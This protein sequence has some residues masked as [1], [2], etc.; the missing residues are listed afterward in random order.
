MSSFSPVFWSLMGLYCLVIIGVAVYFSKFIRNADD[1]FGAS[2]VTP[3]WAAGLSYFMTAFS[4]SAFI[5]AASFTYRFGGLSVM[6]LLLT[7]FT[8]LAG[9]YIFSA[10]W[11]RTGCKT[12]IEFLQ[13][14]FGNRSAKFFVATG[15]PIRILDNANRIYVTGVLTHVILDIPL[16]VGASATALIAF[17]SAV[18]GGFLSVVI[19][20]AI[21]AVVLAIITM[22][23]ATF[24]LIKVGGMGELMASLPQGYWSMS[25]EGSEYNFAFVAALALVGIFS[26]NGYW[27]LV[28]R[29]VSVKTE[30]DARRVSLTSAISYYLLFPLFTLPPIIAVVLVPGLSGAVETEQSYLRLAAMV[31]PAG[32]LGIFFFA[33]VSAAVTSLNAEFNVVAQIVVEDILRPVR[34][35]FVERHGVRLGRVLMALMAFACLVVSLLIPLLGGSY[36]FL[37]TLMGMTTLPTFMPLLFGLL[38]RKTPGWGAML[39]FLLGILI[40]LILGFGFG[41]PLAW[42]IAGNF[43]VTLVTLLVSGYVDSSEHV[44][45]V[46]TL[47][48]RLS[49]RPV[50]EEPEAEAVAEPVAGESAAG[51][52]AAAGKS[53]MVPVLGWSLLILAGISLLALLAPSDSHAPTIVMVISL[54]V[55]GAVLLFFSARARRMAS[56]RA[57]A[58]GR[59]LGA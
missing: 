1:F 55:I 38:W 5:A 4:A 12:A 58:S 48:E 45:S 18:A 41:L 13:H 30:K 16:W 46:V 50:E 20:D 23:I 9:Y 11:H 34:R 40:S 35:S 6:A 21:Q 54:A 19:T 2:R 29:V 7:L 44:P 10:R 15:I 49:R 24:A 22:I 27:S 56:G 33:L 51:A 57:A 37:V 32:M 36:H 3:W 8:F 59:S 17:I 28:Q 14:R 47:F 43:L 31:L 26:W 42:V 39:A 52:A 53:P 25:P